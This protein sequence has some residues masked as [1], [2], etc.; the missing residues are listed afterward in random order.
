MKG[1]QVSKL[2]GADVLEYKELPDPRPEPHQVLIQVRGASVNFADTRARSGGYHLGKKPPFTPGLDSAG[3]VLEVGSEVAQIKEGDHVIAFPASGSY[4]EKAVVNQELTFVIPKTLDFVKASAA[5]LVAGTV[6]HMLQ[7]VARIEEDESLL[8][9]GAAGGVGTTALQVAK[10]AGISRV[11]GSIGSPWKEEHVRKMGAEGI[12]DYSS[13]TYAQNILEMTGNKGVDVILNPIGGETIEQDLICLA[14]FGRLVIFGELGGGPATI[15]QD[16]LYT[17]NKAILG[18]SFGHYRRS[19]PAVVRESMERVIEF[20]AA[21]KIDVF[22]DRCLRLSEASQAHQRL[23]NRE[24]LG[25]I[26]L[27]PDTFYQGE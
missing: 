17:N 9:H 1:I 5:A 21:G 24:A 2:G 20:L 14:P 8:V 13:P 22:V 6:T 16:S 4:A 18:S 10:A 25:K 27:V 15:P 3:I 23:E 26:V 7:Q 19:R 11:F 12:V